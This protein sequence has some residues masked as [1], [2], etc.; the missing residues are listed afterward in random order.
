MIRHAPQDWREALL[1][2]RI[3]LGEGPTP[4]LVRGGRVLDVSRVAPTTSELLARDDLAQ[5]EGRDL[6][7]LDE[8]P[9][10][11]VLIMPRTK[12]QPEA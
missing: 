11:S 9:F 8:L 7:A 1:L 5:A 12:C 3:D 2:G 10:R 4:V 6:G